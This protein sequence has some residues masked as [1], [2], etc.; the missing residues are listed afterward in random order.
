M[1]VVVVV[2]GCWVE[3][4]GGKDGGLTGWLQLQSTEVVKR[5]GVDGAVG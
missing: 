4:V 3:V 5:V 1:V 2:A